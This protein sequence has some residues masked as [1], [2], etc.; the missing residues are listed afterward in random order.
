[1]KNATASRPSGRQISVLGALIV[2][3]ATP[4]TLALSYY[5]LTG[6]P[7]FR[8][9][10]VTVER[11]VADGVE[12]NQ[13]HIRAVIQVADV[14]GGRARALRLGKGIEVAFYGKGIDAVVQ[15][16][17]GSGGVGPTVTFHVARNRFGPYSEAAAAAGARTAI[18]A[19]QLDRAS[20]VADRAHRW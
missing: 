17:P 10:A 15:Y 2:A 18:E 7:T 1:M 8:P 4:A 11:L 9:L 14:P 19:L 6:D 3:I 12:V 5:H 16:E 20:A 13:K